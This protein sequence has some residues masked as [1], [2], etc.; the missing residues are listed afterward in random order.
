MSP[1]KEKKSNQRKKINQ[2]YI[3]QV[4]IDALRSNERES[5]GSKSARKPNI[6]HADGDDHTRKS[7]LKRKSIFPVYQSLK[8][9]KP[10]DASTLELTKRLKDL[11]NIVSKRFSQP[12]AKL[13]PKSLHKTYLNVSKTYFVPLNNKLGLAD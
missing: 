9:S 1:K 7:S 5:H 10:S 4:N 3:I 6:S 12:P 13:N 2:P 11:K 8:I